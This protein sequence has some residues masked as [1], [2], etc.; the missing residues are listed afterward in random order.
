MVEAND[1]EENGAMFA[2]S[3]ETMAAQAMSDMATAVES[4]RGSRERGGI[5]TLF[6]LYISPEMG[7]SLGIHGR[8]AIPLAGAREAVRTKGNK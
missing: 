6:T 5:N 7:E 2:G 3:L 8:L 4:K 1:C